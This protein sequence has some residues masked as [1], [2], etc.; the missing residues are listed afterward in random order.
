MANLENALKEFSEAYNYHAKSN[1]KLYFEDYMRN[2]GM[3]VKSYTTNTSL[4][5]TESVKTLGGKNE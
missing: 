4:D 2:K 3:R 1:N 5:L